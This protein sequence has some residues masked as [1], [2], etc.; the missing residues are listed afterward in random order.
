MNADSVLALMYHGLS[1]DTPAPVVA[2]AHYTLPTPQFAAHLDALIAR[3]IRPGCATDT[4]VHGRAD[5]I[6]TFDDGDISNFAE[7]WPI[8]RRRGLR[9]DFFVNPARVGQPG[10]CSWAQLREMHAG[11]MSIQSHGMTHRYFTRL[12]PQA[13]RDELVQSRERIADHLGTPV[14]W[15]APPGGR[16]P[17]RLGELA[18]EVGYAGVLGSAPGIIR[19]ATANDVVV[20]PRVAVTA[21]TPAEAVCRWALGGNSALR[22]LRWRYRI[23]HTAKRL[24]GDRGYERLRSAML[25][26]AA[27]VQ[28]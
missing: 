16:C 22:G 28:P 10:Y 7:A 15:L 11:G 24:M 5:V 12:T 4:L 19:R 13:L 17:P 14:D 1:G 6:I 18:R 20:L 9:A 25:G 8:L 23:L 2:D 3:G 21:N 27:P 26:Q